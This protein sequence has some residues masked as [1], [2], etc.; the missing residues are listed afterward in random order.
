MLTLSETW[1]NSSIT[2][3]ELEIPGYEL[4]RVDRNTKPGGGVGVYAR[5]TYKVKVLDDIS[6]ISDNGLHQLWINLKVRNLKSIVICTM[7]GPP[8]TPLTCFDTY[9]T[10]SL[11]TA[12]LQNK[13]IYIL[14]DRNCDILKPHCRGAIALT[15]F[16]HS[17]NL[18][19]L[20]SKPTRVTKTTASLIDVIM[21]SNPQQ[22]IET[23]VMPNSISDHDL[24]YVVL[25]IKKERRKLTYDWEKFQGICS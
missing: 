1:L 11:I 8:D 10:P 12:S 2:D 25:Q 22:V 5:Q 6:N 24:P 15:N 3:L 17:F 20:V 4:Y 21:T 7:Y 19:Q 13:P 16:C 14:R 9:L 18:P 23:D